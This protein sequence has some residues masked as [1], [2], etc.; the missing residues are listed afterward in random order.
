MRNGHTPHVTSV[1]TAQSH[2]TNHS[3]HQPLSRN[4][5]C[6]NHS[7]KCSKCGSLTSACDPKETKTFLVSELTIPTHHIWHSRVV[8]YLYV[9]VQLRRKGFF[10]HFLLLAAWRDD[11]CVRREIM[12]ILL[13]SRALKTIIIMKNALNAHFDSDLVLSM[14]ISQWHCTKT[15]LEVTL[16]TELR[17][18]VRFSNMNSLV[19][20]SV[21]ALGRVLIWILTL[22][23]SRSPMRREGGTTLTSLT[24]ASA[25][26][27]RRLSLL[28]PFG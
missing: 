20:P 24:R 1:W 14:W 2:H 8:V 17:W 18:Q 28:L 7:L 21:R 27:L 25:I 4:T 6:W 22:T 23:V 16:H 3:L 10:L 9:A 26:P 5:S 11:G 15:F 19:M 12:W 13:P